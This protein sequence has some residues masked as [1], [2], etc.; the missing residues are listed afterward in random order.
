MKPSHQHYAIEDTTRSPQEY[1]LSHLLSGTYKLPGLEGKRGVLFSNSVLEK[2]IEE[3][4]KHDNFE[5][6][7]E[8]NRS[9]RTLSTGEQKKALL[10]YLL[11]QNPDF[12]VL[13]NPYEALDKESVAVLKQQLITLSKEMPLVF[14]LNRQDD[15]LPVIT[16]I[17]TFEREELKALVPI[18]DYNFKRSEFV[19]DKDI[20]AAITKYTNIP[21]VLVE[22]KNV[23][24]NY[25]NR[26]ILKDISWTIKKKEFW[27]LIGPNGSGKTTLLSMI[28]GNNSKA[29]GQ[30]VYLFGKKKGSGESVWDIKQ[31]IGYISP[32]ILELF[33]RSYTVEQMIVS[34]F[35][36]SIGLYQSPSTAQIHTAA[37]WI[38]VLN[39]NQEKNTSFLKLSPAIQRLILIARAM[40]KHP[41]LL[42]LDEPL[43]N[44]DDQGAALISALIN[45][46]AKESD[47]SI[48]FVSHRDEPNIHPNFTF[49]L[50]SSS[51][52][53]VGIQK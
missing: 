38:D 8:I 34:G 16:H 50:Q 43:I 30:E 35:F 48:L 14:I 40:I 44:V 19:F 5:L 2:Y 53:S 7:S 20:P 46:I 22:L 39:L 4:E 51:K 23:N 32:A 49:A 10:A 24:V 28:Y 17:I 3:E 42:I 27:H 47:T 31:K 15:L 9:L 11:Q 18:E 29:Y 33:K 1:W 37:Q 25:E 26:S 52:G 13:N 12:I 6:T 36:D 45:K 41:P 21:E